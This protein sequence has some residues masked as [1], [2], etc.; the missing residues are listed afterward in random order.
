MYYLRMGEN[1][2]FYSIA[3]KRYRNDLLRDNLAWILTVGAIALVV[4]MGVSKVAKARRK[5]S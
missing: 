5:Q 3:F 2:S 1:Q 4:G